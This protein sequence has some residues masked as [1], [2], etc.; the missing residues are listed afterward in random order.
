LNAVDSSDPCA[1]EGS[2][3]DG[4]GLN[5]PTLGLPWPWNSFCCEGVGRQRPPQNAKVKFRIASQ[6]R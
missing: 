1:A 5:S 6:G 4:L 2:L 3:R